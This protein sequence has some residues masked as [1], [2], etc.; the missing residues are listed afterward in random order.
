MISL[1]FMWK[2]IFGSTLCDRYADIWITN[3]SDFS[4]A[5]CPW[6]AK[7]LQRPCRVTGHFLKESSGLCLWTCS[8]QKLNRSEIMVPDRCVR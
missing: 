6:S 2:Q 4:I 3:S 8:L 7:R 5:R 1:S